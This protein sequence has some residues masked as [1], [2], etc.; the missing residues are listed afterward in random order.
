M[1][2]FA[3]ISLLIGVTAFITGCEGSGDSKDATNQGVVNII[4]DLEQNYWMNHATLT[5]E[6]AH[7]GNVSS[8]VDGNHEFSYGY[9]NS[10]NRISDTLPKAIDIRAWIFCPDS[11]TNANLVISIDSTDKNIFWLG[12][13][14]MDSVPAPNTWKEIHARIE[15][16]E[17]ASKTNTLSIYF[18]T[19]DKKTFFIDDFDLK[20]EL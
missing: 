3:L 6:V 18:W 7:S 4:N 15:M 5:G 12:I 17:K 20:F 9:K 16:P 13:P 1:K 19:L 10:F 8:R 2:K 14:L 11:A